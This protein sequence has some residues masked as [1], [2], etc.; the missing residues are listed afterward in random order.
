MSAMF[1]LMSG[2]NNGGAGGMNGS[3]VTFDPEGNMVPRVTALDKAQMVMD[4]YKG[5]LNGSGNWTEVI[6]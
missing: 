6:T 3:P 2:N 4:E 5:Y 1:F